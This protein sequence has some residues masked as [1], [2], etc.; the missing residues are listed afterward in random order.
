MNLRAPL[1]H[2]HPHVRSG[3][4]LSLGERAADAVKR[5]L[6]SWPFIFTQTG[7]VVVWI[8][9]NI[10]TGHAFDPY[11]FI[12]LNLAFSTQAAYAAPI[13]QLSNNRSDRTSS[14]LAISSHANGEQLLAMNKQQLEILNELRELR[15]L[16]GAP[17]STTQV[18][19]KDGEPA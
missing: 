9:W 2:Q 12:L 15:A 19:T 13:L 4:E 14:E 18:S 17:T 8:V 1:W 16:V 3:A 7:I 11:P 5:G 6:G 10:A